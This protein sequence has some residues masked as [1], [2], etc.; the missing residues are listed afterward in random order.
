MKISQIPPSHIAKQWNSP[1]S[2]SDQQRGR[3]NDQEINIMAL[4]NVDQHV[5]HIATNP[6]AIIQG[7]APEGVTIGEIIETDTPKTSPARVRP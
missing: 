1:E 4:T 2:S 6:D 3:E 5:G 7:E